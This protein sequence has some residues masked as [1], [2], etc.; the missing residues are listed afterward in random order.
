MGPLVPL[1][2]AA[3]VAPLFQPVFLHFLGRD[4]DGEGLFGV[5][6]RLVLVLIGVAAIDTYGALIRSEERGVLAILP[7]DPGMVAWEELR[8]VAR[9][10]AWLPAAAAI[11]LL[12]ITQDVGWQGW[13]ASAGLMAG[14]WLCGLAVSGAVHLSAV[15][16]AEDPR[17]AGVLDMLRGSN[18]REQAAFLWAPGLALALAAFPSA[19]AAEGVRRFTLGDGDAVVS[20]LLPP[21]VAVLAVGRV[22]RL[23]HA[24]WF[25][26]TSVLADI[27]ARYAMIEQ[28]EEATAA[29]LDWLVRFLPAAPALYALKDLRHGW[30]ARRS[31][32]SGMWAVGGV[33][34]LAAWTAD[35]QGVAAAL[36]WTVIGIWSTA[37]V[38]V[39]LE[40]DEPAFLR[41]W[42][43]A[44]PSPQRLARWVVLLAWL[45]PAV[46][47]PSA[48]VLLRHGLV[49]ATVFAAVALASCALAAAAAMT[50]SRWP[51]RGLVA[52]G[53]V[54]ALGAALTSFAAMGGAS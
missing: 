24:G 46:W 20:L 13:A 1:A 47:V 38:G 16:A 50:C 6:I 33:G 28:Q 11:L 5:L 40:R 48:A 21:L 19:V 9:S 8:E 12:P 22:P 39:L 35:P 37:S 49:Q 41:T 29:Y 51:E 30:R 31:W 45:Q 53:P 10:R 18:P 44:A 3:L 54:A 26:A 2:A 43:P 34:A 7:V 17:M 52:Y 32:I 36:A 27:D 14:A 25:R 4:T 15:S 23:A 42:L